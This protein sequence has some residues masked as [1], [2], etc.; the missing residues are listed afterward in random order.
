MGPTGFD[1]AQRS[2]STIREATAVSRAK[3]VNANNDVYDL[4]VAA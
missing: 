4:K 1:G 2:R 3:P